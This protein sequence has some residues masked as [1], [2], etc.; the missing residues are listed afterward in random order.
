MYTA[1]E[2]AAMD[3]IATLQGSALMIDT[4]DGS[5][6]VDG[7]TVI[8]RDVEC[9]NGVIHVIDAVMIPPESWTIFSFWGTVAPS[10]TPNLEW[11]LQPVGGEEIHD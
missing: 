4:S 8:V 5:V 10:P 11:N 1:A 6:Q 2:V 3:S 7:A 9:S